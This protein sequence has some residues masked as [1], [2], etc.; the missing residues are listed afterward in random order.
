MLANET[1]GKISNPRHR[2]YVH[3]ID[4]VG[5]QLTQLADDLIDWTDIETGQLRFKEEYIS[6][7]ELAGEV[8]ALVRPHAQK[9]GVAIRSTQINLSARVLADRRAIRKV[10]L[11]LVSNCVRFT[12]LGG[13]VDVS[14]SVRK[15]G[16]LAIILEDTGI[17]IGREDLDRVMQPFGFAA[18]RFRHVQAN[19]G[20]GMGLPVSKA[21]VERHG[22]TLELNSRI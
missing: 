19:E 1:Y 13:R 12:P 17:G 11:H 9:A 21:L 10:I 22:G 18:E 7:G 3:D 8:I 6:P 14:M 16:S 4:I 20:T 2:E 15:D 5:R